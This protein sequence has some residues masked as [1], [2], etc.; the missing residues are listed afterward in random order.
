MKAENLSVVGKRLPR[1]D[2]VEKATGAARYTIDI[3]LPNMLIGKVLRSPYAHAKIRSIDTSRAEGVAGV[4][5]VVTIEDVPRTPFN[6]SM[7]DAILV[8]PE[9]ELR[10]QYIFD[11]R[12]RF[13]GD[14]VAAIAAS[15]ADIAEE[16]LSLIDVDYEVLPAVFDPIEAM[17]TDAPRI[18]DFAERNIAMHIGDSFTSGDAEKGFQEAD[19][20]VE[21]TFRTSK[22]KVCHIEPTACVAALDSNGRLTVW[23][24]GQHAFPFRKKI[25][26]LFNIPEGKIRWRTPH[27]GGAFGNGQS[28]RAEPICIALALKTGKPVKLEY[29]G[30]EDFVA[31]ETRQP[32][33][34]VGKMGV[35]RDGTITALEMRVISNAGAYFSHSGNTTAVDLCMFKSLYRCSNVTCDANIVYTNTPVSGGHR[36]YG[37]PQ[38]MFVLEQ[39]VDMAAEKIG[40]DPLDFRLRNLK[41]VGD[42]SWIPSI[43]IESSALE[44]CIRRGGEEFGWKERRR[45]RKEGVLKRGTGM[46][47]MMYI[48]SAYPLYFEQGN[49]IIKLNGDGSA[50]LI[51][52]ACDFGQGIL[53]ALAQIAAEELGLCAEDI[54]VTSGDTDTTLY[55]LGQFASRSCYILGN[56]VI[57][58]SRKVKERLLDQAA[59]ML[60]ESAPSLD[61]KDRRI[62][63]KTSAEKGISVAEV[64]KKAFYSSGKHE[65]IASQSTWK[66]TANPNPSQAVFAEVEV[67]TESGDVKILKVVV[68]H[69]IGRAINPNTVE[70]QLEGAVVQSIGYAITEDFK[71]N[72]MNGVLDS[73]SLTD[74][75][76]PSFLDIPEIKVILI[77]EPTPS[78]PFGA[79]SVGESGAIG[80]LPAIYNAVY[81]AVGVRFTEM[82]MT[83]ERILEGL[84][85]RS[86]KAL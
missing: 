75:K 73:N 14:T 4:A 68:V 61:I 8:N 46:A 58:A 25:S 70:G 2:A 64:A 29:T 28:L 21:A 18:H 38:A 31:T 44:D 6:R 20:V 76:I 23:S 72:Q 80:V 5:A 74:Y 84:R 22:Q 43:P 19:F 30:E 77:E 40:M 39:L 65:T 79:K 9:G 67:D 48:S 69:D 83:A 42:P 45:E 36:G 49:V 12:V 34:Q 52:S 66:P 3:K 50:N 85:N 53:A 41:K 60:D 78:G 27:V 82:P 15:D 81:D 57:E 24:P 13:V 47:V 55:D 16:A 32:F 7:A 1:P 51:V 56:A 26:E 54:H 33:I 62:F 37:T 17:K 63:V 71:I 59:I 86:R 10:D 11:R 35:M